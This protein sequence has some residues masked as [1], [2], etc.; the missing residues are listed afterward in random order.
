MAGFISGLRFSAESQD[1]WING[2]K[3]PGVQSVDVSYQRPTTNIRYLGMKSTAQI[4]N[5]PQIGQATVTRQ[6]IS[7]EPFLHLTGLYYWIEGQICDKNENLIFGF[8]YAF[9]NNYNCSCRI[10]EVPIEQAGFVIYGD[11]GKYT[12]PWTPLNFTKRGYFNKLSNHICYLYQEKAGYNEN[13]NWLK[14]VSGAWEIRQ[15]YSKT[16]YKDETIAAASINDYFDPI[17]DI[18]S[19]SAPNAGDPYITIIQSNNMGINYIDPTKFLNTS[20]IFS[21]NKLYPSGA[22]SGNFL[23]KI[24]S[25]SSI[26]VSLDNF[27]TNRVTSFN[28]NIDM[29]RNPI[30]DL[31]G[32]PIFNYEMLW[33]VKVE[34]NWP[35][36]VT[37]NFEIEVDTYNAGNIKQ[38]IFRPRVQ[39]FSLKLKDYKTN[40]LMTDYNFA[41]MFLVGEAYSVNIGENTKINATYKTYLD[42]PVGLFDRYYSGTSI[43]VPSQP[44]LNLENSSGNSVIISALNITGITY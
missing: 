1:F 27:S 20:S 17:F 3:I 26:D 15:Y 31:G 38:S 4:P 2:V 24:P 18:Y 10:G 32:F 21:L 7:D 9:L 39:N 37:C 12:K 36:E 30:Y 29:P 8:D 13:M 34:V 40:E 5:G 35:I 43:S 11:I 6:F 44:I 14:A 41:D 28:L 42:R 25:Y 19:P 23:I 22:S 33:P 16:E